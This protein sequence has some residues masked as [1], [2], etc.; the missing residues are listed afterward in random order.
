[1]VVAREDEPGVLTNFYSVPVAAGIEV[2]AKIHAAYVEIWHQGKCLARHERCFGR[3]QKVLEL[4][5][6]PKLT[7]QG[8]F[9]VTSTGNKI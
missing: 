2:Q 3:Q 5:R 6:S 7:Q 9:E 1:M 4:R 8:L